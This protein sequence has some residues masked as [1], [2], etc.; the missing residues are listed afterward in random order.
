MTPFRIR[1]LRRGNGIRS[2]LNTLKHLYVSTTKPTHVGD[3]PIADTGVV[4]LRR[5]SARKNSPSRIM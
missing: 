4:L 5:T 2:T 3:E 1:K